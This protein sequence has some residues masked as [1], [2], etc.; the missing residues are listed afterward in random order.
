MVPDPMARYKQLLYFANKLEKLPV[1][2][3]VPQN[4]VE[5]CVSQ[6]SLVI[7]SFPHLIVHATQTRKGGEH[8]HTYAHTNRHAYARTHTHTHTHTHTRTHTHTHTH[9]HTHTH[10]HA[11]T[12]THTHTYTQRHTLF[13][14]ECL[15]V[16]LTNEASF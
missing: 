1:D 13:A 11:H 16:S 14:L 9:I 3:H 6:V 12:Y 4:K 10:T 5:G 7:P 2:D 15:I 8:I